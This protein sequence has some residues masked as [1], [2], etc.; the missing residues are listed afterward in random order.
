[1]EL[2]KSIVSMLAYASLGFTLTAAYLQINKIWK[3]KHVSEVA[4]SVSI[5]G[6]VVD[7]IPT[8]FF[9]LNYLLIA[10][11]QGLI[12]SAIWIVFGFVIILIGSG[13]WVEENRHKTSWRRWMDAL[14]LEKSEVGDLAKSFFRPSGARLILEIFAHIAYVDRELEEREKELIQAFGDNWK[15]AIDWNKYDQLATLEGTASLIE[16]RATV[17][18]Y[19]KTSPP[20]RQVAQLIDVLQALV[21]IDENVSAEE[22]IILDETHGLLRN[23]IDETESSPTYAVVIAPQNRKQD[24]ALHSLLPDVEKMDVAGGSGYVVGAYFSQDYAN[25]VRNQY[26][27]L[28]FFTVDM[29]TEAN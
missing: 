5:V 25:K 18:R 14:R 9:G 26:R 24:A 10:Q 12:N 4:N 16:A 7:I 28:G 2:F 13:L 29:S 6:N 1:M 3:R 19:L 27:S 20:D 8:F 21:D 17:D 11:W 23:Y 15:V 22:K